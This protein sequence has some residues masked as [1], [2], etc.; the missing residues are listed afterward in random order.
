[1]ERLFL[2]ANV[3]VDGMVSRWSASRAVLILCSQ[4]VVRLVVAQYVL[5]EVED[6]FL[7]MG[8]RNRL[9]EKDLNRVIEDYE[10]FVRL[11][12]PEIINV[13]SH[14]AVMQQAAIIH[15]LHDVPVLAAALKAQPDWLLSR[16]RNHF[17]N[18]IA[19]RT[20]LQIGDPLEYLRAKAGSS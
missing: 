4:R 5:G 15:H 18:Q 1:M 13:A 2:D 16:N 12:Q 20:G 6:A 9:S 17:S 3:I 11:A 7:T 8:Q 19:Q 14:E 10:K